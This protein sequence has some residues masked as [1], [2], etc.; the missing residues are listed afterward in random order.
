MALSDVIMLFSSCQERVQIND[1]PPGTHSASGVRSLVAAAAHD[2]VPEDAIQALMA[3]SISGAASWMAL[4]CP[5]QDP[6]KLCKLLEI[7]ICMFELNRMDAGAGRDEKI[8]GT[9]TDARSAC[10]IAE[11]AGE[12]PNGVGDRQLRQHLFVVA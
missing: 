9:R 5:S 2:L 12:C 3:G 4:D 10:T 1:G 6:L 7:G 8:P 11:V